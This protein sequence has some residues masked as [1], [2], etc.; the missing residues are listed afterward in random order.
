MPSWWQFVHMF[1]PGL[2]AEAAASCS[3]AVPGAACLHTW[4]PVHSPRM[5]PATQRSLPDS[6][7]SFLS[8][9]ERSAGTYN[10]QCHIKQVATTTVA[11]EQ[12]Q[13]CPGQ[14]MGLRATIC[15]RGVC[16]RTTVARSEPPCCIA[17][18]PHSAPSSRALWMVTVS[19]RLISTAMALHGRGCRTTEDGWGCHRGAQRR[20][21]QHWLAFPDAHSLPSSMTR[22][23]QAYR[24]KLSRQPKR[25]EQPHLV[26]SK[27]A[28]AP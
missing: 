7:P 9:S 4:L 5:A 2:L 18:S 22:M 20:P 21:A 19:L 15:G 11:K 25:V 10:C 27:A 1:L 16:C 14:H 23:L 24:W 13:C 8:G 6:K 17:A 3:N 26:S 28:S 12:Q